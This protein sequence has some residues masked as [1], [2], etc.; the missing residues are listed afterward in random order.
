MKKIVWIVIILGAVMVGAG[1]IIYNFS[2]PKVENEKEK[3]EFK[4]YKQ[5]PM[6]QNTEVC[7]L[8]DAD[9]SLISSNT[10]IKE[11]SD[12]ITEINNKTKEDYEMLISSPTDGL[13]ACAQ[14]K[15]IYKYSTYITANYKLYEDN[16]IVSIAVNKTTQNL[17]TN[18]EETT[19]YDVIIYDKKNKKELTKKD[20]LKKINYTENM[21][22]DTITLAIESENI[23]SENPTTLESEFEFTED[24]LIYNLFY[25]TDGNLTLSYQVRKPDTI[26][27]GQVMI[28]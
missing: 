24:E 20:I 2:N 15:D 12:K 16:N 6:C 5:V 1:I 27:N 23:N 25:S 3:F 17:C 18:S 7:E 9:F 8:A 26:I 22:K 10:K 13:E 14:V 11:I 4:T 19:P 21:I 28:G